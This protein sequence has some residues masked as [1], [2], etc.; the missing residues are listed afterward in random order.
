MVV[1]G[2]ALVARE[3]ALEN[4]RMFYGGF[5]SPPFPI[6]ALHHI[7]FFSV[8]WLSGSRHCLCIWF[9]FICLVPFCLLSLFVFISFSHSSLLRYIYIYIS[10]CVCFRFSIFSLSLS[11]LYF[12]SLPSIS[13]FLPLPPSLYVSRL[14]LIFLTCGFEECTDFPGQ[15]GSSVRDMDQAC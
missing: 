7:I 14:S 9:S 13:L 6:V 15:F 8:H 11:S 12:F 3:G 4:S 10:V 5:P 2:S 1:V